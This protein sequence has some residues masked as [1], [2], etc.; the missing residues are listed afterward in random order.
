MNMPMAYN[1]L[2]GDAGSSLSGGQR[3]R[4]LLARA[5]YRRPR[6]MF[7]DEGTSNLDVL[8]EQR[9]TQAIS[10]LRMTRVVIAHRPETINAASRVLVIGSTGLHAVEKEAVLF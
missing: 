10:T 8:T 1:S 6:L 4:V 2:I 7:L 3:Q 5:L 9:V